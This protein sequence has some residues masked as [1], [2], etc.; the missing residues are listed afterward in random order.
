MNGWALQQ[1]YDARQ[2]FQLGASGP[3]NQLSQLPWGA[4]RLRRRR[5]R[6]LVMLCPA[7]L[8]CQAAAA[9][10]ETSRAASDYSRNPAAVTS[11]KWLWLTWLW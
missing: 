7:W 10:S 4:D 11:P 8:T 6:L 9:S 5:R 2:W 3:G 1:P